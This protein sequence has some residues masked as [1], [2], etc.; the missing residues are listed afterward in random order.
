MKSLKSDMIYSPSLHNPA[1][2]TFASNRD[3]E[4]Q[5]KTAFTIFFAIQTAKPDDPKNSDHA[6][7]TSQCGARRSSRRFLAAHLDFYFSVGD[8]EYLTLRA[9]SLYVILHSNVY[10]LRDR[11]GEGSLPTFRTMAFRSGTGFL[12]PKVGW[13]A[14]FPRWG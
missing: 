14:H 11:T 4:N 10:R 9:F 6:R 3:R 13:M 8:P 2:F 5:H 1:I 7:T 12:V